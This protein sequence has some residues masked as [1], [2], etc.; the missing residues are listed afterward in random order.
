[1]GWEKPRKMLQ[2][3]AH[4]EA[5]RFLLGV[6]LSRK[7]ALSADGAPMRQRSVTR[8]RCGTDDPALCGVPRDIVRPP[9]PPMKSSHAQGEAGVAAARDAIINTVS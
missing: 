7:T 6:E 9:R 4:F 3:D 2:I 8:K 5:N 1:M